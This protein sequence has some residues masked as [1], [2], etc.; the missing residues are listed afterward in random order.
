MTYLPAIVTG[1][2]FYL[3]LILDLYSRKI[4]GW[5]V[6]A[7]DHSDHAVHLVR[8]SAVPEEIATSVG[9]AISQNRRKLIEQS[10]GWVKTVGRMRQ[11]MV[12]GLKRVDQMFVMTMAA[13]NLTFMRTLG[14]IRPLAV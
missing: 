6:H 5:E 13:Y 14:Q 11:V 4:V 1:S 3:Y 12:C 7:S 10:F 8:R 2:W 9:Y